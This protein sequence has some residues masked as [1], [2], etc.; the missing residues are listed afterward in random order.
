MLATLH[1]LVCVCFYGSNPT[2]FLFKS[3]LLLSSMLLT[4]TAHHLP[5]LLRTSLP[6]SWT[7]LTFLI[8]LMELICSEIRQRI[9]SLSAW[10]ESCYGSTP[11]LQY[12][13]Q[14]LCS[15]TG[16]QQGDPL[17]PL[18]FVLALH[19]IV[20]QLSTTTPL[21]AFVC[22]IWMMACLLVLL[23]Q[24]AV[25]PIKLDDP[26][27]RLSLNK[28]KCLLSLPPDLNLRVNPFPQRSLSLLGASLFWVSSLALL[29]CFIISFQHYL[30][31][32]SVSFSPSDA[33]MES[34]L[35]PAA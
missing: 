26:P 18:G 4:S 15:C 27:R 34:I 33:Q 12:L 24:Q 5:H 11:V 2:L 13:D 9:S 20:E 6:S 19:P 16:V 28:F 29:F 23:L 22:G 30:Q 10:F 17:G 8:L 14:S 7:F 35:F 32:K 25:E 1:G 21:S 31:A 3:F